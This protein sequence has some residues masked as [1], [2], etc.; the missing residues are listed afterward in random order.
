EPVPQNRYVLLQSRWLAVMRYSIADDIEPNASFPQFGDDVVYIERGTILHVL[1]D[2]L[3][4]D[5]HRVPG[6][7]PEGS[8]HAAQAASFAVH[9]SLFRS[10][11]SRRYSVLDGAASWGAPKVLGPNALRF[12]VARGAGT[13]HGRRLAPNAFTARPPASRGWPLIQKEGRAGG[14]TDAFRRFGDG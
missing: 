1:G 6:T 2:F 10:S 13:S 11:I 12:S 9:S 5:G 8:L 3:D 7:V 4:Q 14:H